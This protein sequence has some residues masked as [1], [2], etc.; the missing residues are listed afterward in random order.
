VS[1]ASW[2]TKR[3][4]PS[5]NNPFYDLNKLPAICP[6]CAYSFDPASVKVKRRHSRKSANE[7]EEN[8]V[9]SVSLSQRKNGA[10]QIDSDEDELADNLMEL[11]EGDDIDNLQEI[12]EID[13]IEE[14]H[15]NEDDA[16]EEALIEELDTAGNNIIGD[17][18]EEEELAL[19][20]ERKE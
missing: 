1:K 4:C 11:D 6:K 13:D 5:C 19:E 3:N 16:D 14:T 17:I 8:D 9:Q 18:Q 20:R 12:A 7:T 15:T 10:R 2:G